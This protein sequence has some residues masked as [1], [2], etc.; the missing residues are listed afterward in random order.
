MTPATIEADLH[1]FNDIRAWMY[2]AQFASSDSLRHSFL[3]KCLD[4]IRDHRAIDGQS[5]KLPANTSLRPV[6]QLWTHALPFMQQTVLLTA[7]RGPDGISKYGSV[8]MLLR[9]FR[10]CLLISS[11]EKIVLAD[12]Y[13]PRGGSFT[14]PSLTHAGVLLEDWE[15]GM[16]RH[17]DEYVK[18]LDSMPHHFQLH[19]M[20][21][22]E[23]MGFKHSDARIRSWWHSVYLR[24]VNDMHLHPETLEELNER[25][26]DN[27]DGWL[28][29]ADRATIS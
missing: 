17:V 16:D 18:A 22:I 13:D 8:K 20:H 2:D 29:R 7:I 5:T 26:G 6:T 23:I 3:Q 27:V 1:C 9:W 12:P 25:L 15:L 28:R 21:A 11:M 10:R 14:G 4:R 19:L 24:L